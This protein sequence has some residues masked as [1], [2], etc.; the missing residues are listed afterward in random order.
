MESLNLE[1]G[2]STNLKLPVPS[3]MLAFNPKGN[4]ERQNPFQRFSGPIG[5]VKFTATMGRRF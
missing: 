2:G 3:E 4:P 1:K 5:F